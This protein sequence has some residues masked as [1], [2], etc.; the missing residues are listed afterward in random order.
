MSLTTIEVKQVWLL[1][2]QLLRADSATALVGGLAQVDYQIS[3][4]PAQDT[5]AVP[6]PAAAWL[7]GSG[8]LALAGLSRRKAKAL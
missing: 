4:A 8:L 7:F 6:L 3:F 2:N 5:A 1:S